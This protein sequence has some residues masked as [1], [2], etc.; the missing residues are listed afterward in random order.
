MLNLIWPNRKK[1]PNRQSAQ[2]YKLFSQIP[3]GQ[4]ITTWTMLLS[5]IFTTLAMRC[6]FLKWVAWH[7]IF[8]V[9]LGDLLARP[10]GRMSLS[11]AGLGK[12]IEVLI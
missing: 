11:H 3:C 12:F 5:T 1:L 9:E 8:C 7:L 10:N 6:T 4:L 2:Y